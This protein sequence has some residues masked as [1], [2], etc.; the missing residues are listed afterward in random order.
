MGPNQSKQIPELLT[1]FDLLKDIKRRSVKTRNSRNRLDV[2][3]CDVCVAKVGAGLVY[4][5]PE[6]GHELDRKLALNK[7]YTG[8]KGGIIVTSGL[9]ECHRTQDSPRAKGKLPT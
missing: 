4:Q 5:K 2:I 8:R 1:R 9:C 6:Q 3:E 7:R